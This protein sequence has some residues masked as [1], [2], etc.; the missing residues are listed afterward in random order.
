M[1]ASFDMPATL[2][3]DIFALSARRSSVLSFERSAITERPYGVI[4]DRFRQELALR[5]AF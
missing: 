1:S 2:L 5:I 3:P 4:P